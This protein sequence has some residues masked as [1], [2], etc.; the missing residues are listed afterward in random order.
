MRT[1]Q[2]ALLILVAFVGWEFFQTRSNYYEKVSVSETVKFAEKTL[3]LLDA[4]H[5]QHHRF[6]SELSE[7]NLPRG[8][9]GYTP[10]L[11]IDHHSS[12]LNVQIESIEGSYGTFKYTPKVI[13]GKIFWRC[14]NVSA[15]R[16]VLPMHC[17][18]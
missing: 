15:P 13:Q 12:T 18:Q 2:I 7:L 1:G 6:P 10:K 16:D 8:E 11:G 4:Y 14:K 3:A 5:E 17:E 9:D